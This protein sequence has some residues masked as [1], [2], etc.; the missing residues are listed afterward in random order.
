MAIH[1]AINTGFN[2]SFDNNNTMPWIDEPCD[3]IAKLDFILSDAVATQNDAVGLVYLVCPALQNSFQIVYVALCW[4]DDKRESG[5]RPA[6]HRIDIAES[7][8]RGDSAERVGIVDYGREP[9][10]PW[11]AACPPPA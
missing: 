7:I 4:V 6:A 5:N 11:R 10:A 9:S 3:G 1:V 2:K 8:R